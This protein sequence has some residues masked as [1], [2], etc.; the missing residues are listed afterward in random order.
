MTKPRCKFR[1][2]D[3]VHLKLPGSKIIR[4]GETYMV[5]GDQ[6]NTLGG[7]RLYLIENVAFPNHPTFWIPEGWLEGATK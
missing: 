7:E 3:R 6:D 1:I 5:L 2:G 4:A